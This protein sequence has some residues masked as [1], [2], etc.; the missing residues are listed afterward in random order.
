[1]TPKLTIGSI[2]PVFPRLRF[3]I[4]LSSSEARLAAKPECAKEADASNAPALPK[5]VFCKNSLLLK[6]FVSIL[7]F[8]C[9]VIIDLSDNKK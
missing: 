7:V 5:I 4:G 3:I 6:S 8:L 2:I 9:L 1:M